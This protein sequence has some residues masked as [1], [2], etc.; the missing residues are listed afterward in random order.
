MVASNVEG[1][2]AL[3]VLLVKGLDFRLLF[4]IGSP[5]RRRIEVRERAAPMGAQALLNE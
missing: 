1:T 2:G 4:D 5:E 3:R